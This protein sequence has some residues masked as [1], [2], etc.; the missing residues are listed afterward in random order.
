M[1]EVGSE[2]AS[3]GWFGKTKRLNDTTKKFTA[4]NAERRINLQI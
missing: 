1:G 4:E 2:A 3:E